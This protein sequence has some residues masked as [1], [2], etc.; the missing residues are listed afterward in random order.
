MFDALR[1]GIVP[2][3]IMMAM[4]EIDVLFVKDGGPLERS[5]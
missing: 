5:G 1:C 2:L 3:Q 4:R